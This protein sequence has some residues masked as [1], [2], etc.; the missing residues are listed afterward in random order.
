M[1]EVGMAGIFPHVQD[2]TAWLARSKWAQAQQIK[3][4][5]PT[6]SDIEGRNCGSCTVRA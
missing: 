5:Y 4:R 3:I 6:A 1:D 2:I